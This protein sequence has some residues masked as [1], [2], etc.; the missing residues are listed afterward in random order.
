ML[1]CVATRR[2]R[3][4]SWGM[5]TKRAGCCWRWRRMRKWIDVRRDAVQ[6]LGQLGHMNEA[7]KL[8]LALAE[9][10]K[11]TLGVRFTAVTALGRLGHVDE[12]ISSRLLALAGDKKVGDWV[13]GA[14]VE[15]LG[16]VEYADEVVLDGL[17]ALA[18]NKKVANKVRGAAAGA[19]G[20]LGR[21]MKQAD[22]CWR[23][24]R[25]RKWMLKCMRCGGGV[26]EFGACG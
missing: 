4:C 18:D 7:A 9:N 26:R 2:R 25:I 3:W 17:L 22:C 12:S 14:V 1:T 6:A 23:W 15:V 8:L 5:W 20:R 16:Q 11:L 21:S 10:E 13:R 24:Q 19:L